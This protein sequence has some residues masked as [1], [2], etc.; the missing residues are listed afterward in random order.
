M[1]GFIGGISI[2]AGMFLIGVWLD[3]KKSKEPLVFGLLGVLM[4]LSLILIP[5]KPQ[6]ETP[7]YSSEWIDEETKCHFWNGSPVSCETVRY[8]GEL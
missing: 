3:D 6:A 5:Q 4:G 1:I 8:V 7:T 2:V